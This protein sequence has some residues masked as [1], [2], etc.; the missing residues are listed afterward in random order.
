MVGRTAEGGCPPLSEE[1]PADHSLLVGLVRQQPADDVAWH[2]PVVAV[3]PDI[4][5]CRALGDDVRP[6][7]RKPQNPLAPQLEILRPQVNP[8]CPRVLLHGFAVDWR[9]RV[10]G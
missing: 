10:I 1:P 6:R 5:C 4:E 7:L 3:F 8:S 9:W 2:K